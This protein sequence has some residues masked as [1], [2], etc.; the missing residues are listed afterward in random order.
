MKRLAVLAFGLVSYAVFLGTFLYLAGFTANLLVPKS[1]DSAPVTPLWS[2]LLVNTLLVVLFAVQHTVMARPTFKQWWTRFVPQPVERSTYVLLTCLALILLF[3]QWRPM[4]G[5]IWDFRQPAAR[6]AFYAICAVGWLTVLVSTCLINHFDLFGLR[7]VWLYFRGKPYTQLGFVTPGP[8]KLIRHP[9]YVGW[10]IAFWATPTMSAAHLL[11]ATGM[12]AYM[13]VAIP[14]EERNLL[15]FHGE[16]YA[17]YRRRV[18]MLLPLRSK[19]AQSSQLL[20]A[21]PA[22]AAPEASER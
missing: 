19:A 1:M 21:E 4:G 7:Q 14:F 22:V 8:Y 12:T 20:E 2:A 3:W 6:A 13:L 11:F 18:P 16:K 5:I 9:L 10:M 17:M 15:D